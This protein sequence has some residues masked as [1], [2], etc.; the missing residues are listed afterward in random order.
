MRNIRRTSLIR[1]D[2]HDMDQLMRA[3]AR[4]YVLDHDQDG[5]AAAAALAALAAAAA[6]LAVLITRRRR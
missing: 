6:A 3:T 1:A 5:S 4:P 2:L